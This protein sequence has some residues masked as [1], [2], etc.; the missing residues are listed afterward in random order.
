MASGGSTL[1]PG[2]DTAPPPNLAQAPKFSAG[3]SGGQRNFALQLQYEMSKSKRAFSFPR[4]PEHTIIYH[5]K[6]VHKKDENK[7]YNKQIPKL[8]GEE[9]VAKDPLVTMGCPK[10]TLQNCPFPFDDHHLHLIHP[11]LDGPHSTSN[12]IQIRLAVLP[13]YTF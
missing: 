4:P 13:Q 8:I 2:G 1:G 9:C 7:P 10:F 3:A 12:G 6:T 11:S 5:I